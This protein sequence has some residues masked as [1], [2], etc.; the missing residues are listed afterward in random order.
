M[1]R[2][3]HSSIYR[4]G[5]SRRVSSRR[6]PM[7]TSAARAG[8][9]RVL[10][11]RRLGG[12]LLCGAITRPHDDVDIAVW[13]DDVPRIAALLAASGWRACARPGRGRWHGLRARRGAPRADVPRSTRRRPRSSSLCATSRRRGPRARSRRTRPVAARRASAHVIA[14]DALTQRQ[15]LDEGR[16]RRRGEGPGRPRCPVWPLRRSVASGSREH[17]S[18]RD[19][20]E[21]RRP[22]GRAADARRRAGNARAHR[23]PPRRRRARDAATPPS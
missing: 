2:R 13:R 3:S 12:R 9:D 22:A 20:R 19:P 15:V 10:A 23:R 8:R 21:P 18:A 17:R 6:S 16:R 14:L 11:L 5:A 1:V 4:G 7:S